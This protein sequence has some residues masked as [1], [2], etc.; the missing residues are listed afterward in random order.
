MIDLHHVPNIRDS[1][2]L[3]KGYKIETGVAIGLPSKVH[4]ILKTKRFSDALNARDLLAREIYN[5]RRNSPIPSSVL[6]KMVELN[7]K[8]YP[9][10]FKR[11]Y[12]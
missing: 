9:D 1:K 2:R 10:T 11:N 4:R 12:K 5:L 8:K 7:K 3:I 6:L